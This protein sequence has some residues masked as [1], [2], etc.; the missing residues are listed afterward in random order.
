MGSGIGKSEI[1]FQSAFQVAKRNGTNSFFS[2][3]CFCHALVC[4]LHATV[5]LQ[6][7]PCAVCLLSTCWFASACVLISIQVACHNYGGTKCKG[8]LQI[9]CTSVPGKQRPNMLKS[10]RQPKSAHL[11]VT[12]FSLLQMFFSQI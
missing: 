4:N 11:R 6:Q 5:K 1:C 3:D 8:F 12:S 7:A 2:F 10:T 9:S